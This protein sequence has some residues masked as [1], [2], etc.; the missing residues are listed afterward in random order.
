M[1]LPKTNENKCPQKD[2][3]RNIHSNPIHKN[4]KPQAFPMSIKSSMNKIMVQSHNEILI[5]N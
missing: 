4:Q 2:S 3:Y 5:N 1:Y